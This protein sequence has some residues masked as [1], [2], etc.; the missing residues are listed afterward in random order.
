MYCHFHL[1]KT[2][3]FKDPDNAVARSF[4]GRVN[5]RSAAAAYHFRKGS[6]IQK[7]VHKLKYKGDQHIGVYMGQLIGAMLIGAN[8][9]KDAQWIIPIPLHAQKLRKRGYNQSECIGR[10][11]SEAS[12]IPLE[13]DCLLRKT[14]SSTQTK[15]SRYARWENVADVF[16]V[17]NPDRIRGAHIIL[18]DDVITTGATLE[19]GAQTLLKAGA[20][21]VSILAFASTL[22]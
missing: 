15:K 3:Y 21:S 18:L 14:V 20:A 1:P 7:M 8:D 17:K 22:R 16:R 6:S 2:D 10:G 12:G 11:L 13:S 19:A 9:F 5:I 4:Y